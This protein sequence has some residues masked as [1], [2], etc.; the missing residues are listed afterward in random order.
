MKKIVHT[1]II[2]NTL[3][4]LEGAIEIILAINN[5]LTTVHLLNAPVIRASFYCPITFHAKTLTNA[6]MEPINAIYKPILALIM[7]EVIG[8]S[9]KM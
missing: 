6:K 7:L 5:V 2:N 3:F 9:Q 8:V 4:S 1:F